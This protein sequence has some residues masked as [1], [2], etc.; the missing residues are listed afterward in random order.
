MAFPLPLN[1]QPM[2]ARLV[3]ELPTDGGW[4]FEPKWD[5]FRCLAFKSGKQVEL[6]AKSGKS[7]AR[8]FPDV[9]EC[10]RALPARK[11]VCDGELVIVARDRVSF[12]DLQLR[13]HPAASRVAKLAAA[14]PAHLLWFDCLANETSV[15]LS[16]PLVQRRAALEKLAGRGSSCISVSPFTR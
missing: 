9:I 7:L 4:Q 2:E 3:A 1:T 15:L 12:A 11:F 14:Q 8:Y 6:R 5:G 10:L 13:L 16:A